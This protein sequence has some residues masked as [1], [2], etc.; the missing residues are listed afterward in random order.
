M[1]N[2]DYSKTPLRVL[3]QYFRPHRG[4]F[5]LDLSCALV[6][7]LIDLAFPLVARSAMNQLLPAR[8]FDTFFIVMLIVA[9]AFVIRACM[10]YII[11]Y[12]GHMFGVRVEADL[13]DD[14]FR[15]MQSLD[16]KF[17]DSNRTCLKLQSYRIM[18]RR[19]CL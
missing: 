19:I 7:A 4:L 11:T 14:L 6:M 13:R 12:W 3:V 8:Q 16:F 18:D 2:K 10:N 1:N 17:F 5:V 15:H 9:A